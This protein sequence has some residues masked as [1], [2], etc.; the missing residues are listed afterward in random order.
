MSVIDIIIRHPR[1]YLHIVLI[2]Y[3]YN[4][5]SILIVAEADFSSLIVLV[6]TLVDH[7]LSIMNIAVLS[8]TSSKLRIEWISDVNNMKSTGASA[9]PHRIHESGFLIQ[10]NVVGATKII[11]VGGLLEKVDTGLSYFEI[12]QLSEVIDL[13]SM[14]RCLTPNESMIS[15]DLLIH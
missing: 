8:K 2:L 13:Q 1:Q 10:D 9:T 15:I 12:S 6:W 3:I 11:I 4:S 5:Q 7:T 14:V